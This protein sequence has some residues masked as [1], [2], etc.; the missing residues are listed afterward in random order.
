MALRQ[1]KA[2]GVLCFREEPERAFLL[3][4]HP[5]RWDLPK[6]HIKRHETER[7]CALREFEEETGINPDQFIINPDYR[8]ELQRQFQAERFKG[9]LV[10]KTYVIFLGHI[11]GEVAVVPTEHQGFQWVCWQPPHQISEWLIDP[12]LRNVEHFLDQST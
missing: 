9:K 12:L 4:K 5:D 10:C 7:E 1:V 11:Q 2:C 3:M 6:G 8:F